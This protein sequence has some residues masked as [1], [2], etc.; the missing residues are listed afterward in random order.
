MYGD[1]FFYSKQRNTWKLKNER[2][3]CFN[4]K[5]TPKENLNNDKR[6]TNQNLNK[7]TI[8]DSVSL[9]LKIYFTEL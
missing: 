8:F 3:F 5:L 6:G 1:I 9:L 4:I 2:G 7:Y